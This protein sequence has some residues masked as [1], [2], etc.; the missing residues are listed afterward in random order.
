MVAE[1]LLLLCT[2]LVLQ[3]HHYKVF[4]N[5]QSLQT[6]P[7]LGSVQGALYSKQRSA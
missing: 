4:L 5:K 7:Y 6:P 1:S 3:A 2:T